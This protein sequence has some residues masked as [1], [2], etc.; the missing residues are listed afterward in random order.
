MLKRTF[1][2]AG[3][4]ATIAL[5]VSHA[6]T[7]QPII[8][9]GTQTTSVLSYLSDGSYLFGITVALGSDQFLLPVEITGAAKLQSWQFDVTFDNTV[10][11]EVDPGDGTSWIYGA[12]FTSGDTNSLSF[13]LG[14]FPINDFD[15][16]SHIGLVDDVAGFYP[17]L[18]DGPSGDGILAYVLF[19][20]LPNQQTNNPGFSIENPTIT[21]SVP[22][23][24]TI[25][26]LSGGLAGLF[27][28]RYQRMRRG[29]PEV[30]PA[31]FT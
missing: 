5:F 15:L 10:V 23:P 27:G 25:A 13:I 17:S 4:F 29:R 30:P 20:Y 2:T 24:A 6:A 18:L 28:V 9:L 19:E 16:I 11:Q 31:D 26:L 14:G 3:A 22:A 8:S 1:S 21:E 12:E 7:A